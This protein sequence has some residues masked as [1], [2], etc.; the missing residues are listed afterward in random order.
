MQLVY[1]ASPRFVRIPNVNEFPYVPIATRRYRV[2]V[3]VGRLR[4]SSTHTGRC[5][6][7]S[8]TT[9]TSPRSGTHTPTETS[10][11]ILPAGDAWIVLAS[12]CCGDPE[13]GI[14]DYT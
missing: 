7:G 6:A 3:L 8:G 13:I 1:S 4:D 10:P 9:A 5:E 12:D 14:V 2:P 11:D